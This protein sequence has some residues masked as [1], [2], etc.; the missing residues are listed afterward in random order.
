VSSAVSTLS[1]LMS[2]E[3]PVAPLLYGADWD[4]Y[5][6]TQFTGWPT[7]SNPYMDP[8]PNDPELPYILMHLK[9]AS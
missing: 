1:S 5:S 8:S 6:T 7:A 3:V 2:T 4:E 9:V